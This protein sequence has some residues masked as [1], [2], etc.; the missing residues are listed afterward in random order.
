M[1]SMPINKPTK[2]RRQTG[3][4]V[5]VST[6]W[7][8][9]AASVLNGRRWL[10]R[11]QI[12]DYPIIVLDGE[13]E[14]RIPQLPWWSSF[15]PLRKAPM[16][17]EALNDALQKIARDPLTKGVLFYFKSPTISFAQAQSFA[18]LFDRFRSSSK[19]GGSAKEVIALIE[20]VNTQ[21]YLA[22]SAAD[23]LYMTPLSEWPVVGLRM[24]QLYLKETLKQI[25]V[26][27]EVIKIAP[28][29][30]A[31]D[32]MSRSTM[33]KEAKAQIG[34][35][36]DGLYNE[37]VRSIGQGRKIP[38]TQVEALIDQAPLSAEEAMA[39][40]LIDGI[41]YEDEVVSLLNAGDETVT[42]KPYRKC[43]HLL[44]RSAQRRMGT[45][46]VMSAGGIIITGSSRNSPVPLPILGK[47]QMG[48]STVQQ[49]IRA[50]REDKHLDAIVFHV[51]SQGGSALASD[52]MWRELTL[53]AQ[54][55]PLVVYMGDVAASGG[56]YVSAP[57]HKIV[58]QR[59]TITGSIGVVMAKPVNKETYKKIAAKPYTFQKG[60][61][62]GLMSTSVHWTAKQKKLLIKSVEHIYHEFKERVATGRGLDYDTLDPICQGR[63]WLGTQ[64]LEHGLVDAIG[65]IQTA[66]EYA[67][68]LANLPADGRTK[69]VNV[70]PPKE[71]V[72]AEPFIN[73]EEMADLTSLRDLG[74]LAAN[75]LQ[76]NWREILGNEQAWLIA[77][78]LPR[79]K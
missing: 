20:S 61:N 63:V 72:M 52:L 34:W 25:G 59:S 19:K 70:Y 67:C 26:D 44:L 43:G 10:L 6:W 11:K 73:L 41:A 33:S 27:F 69:I 48:S 49:Q 30:T 18:L 62:A 56:Y 71:P 8:F 14:E 35:L 45:V 5:V 23:R 65:D 38:T 7:T 17:M 1:T 50:A 64:A 66:L 54:E 47:K 2:H 4:R 12:P 16:T 78:W 32:N 37:I 29:K 55:K 24:E 39:A 76:G 79:V 46:G 58:C 74:Q 22:A 36:L 60:A 15:V 42:L 51:D 77:D 53:L 9:L 28:W 40:D 75:V 13:I 31:M 3:L 21:G 68:D 57:G